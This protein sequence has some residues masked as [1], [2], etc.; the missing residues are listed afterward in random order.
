[1][2]KLG[3]HLRDP[4]VPTDLAW[5]DALSIPP[6]ACERTAHINATI[7]K[8]LTEQSLEAFQRTAM[9]IRH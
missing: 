6:E 4:K 1:M 3:V 8:R 5:V 2:K 7:F 9:G